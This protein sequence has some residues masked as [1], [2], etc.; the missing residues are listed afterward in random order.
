MSRS[1][2]S[3]LRGLG[4]KVAAATVLGVIVFALLSFYGDVRA[5]QKNL[6]AFDWW[7][8]VPGFA[9]ATANYAVRFLRWQ[10]YL[11]ILGISVPV[12]ES[13]LVFTS[14]FVMSV[15]PGKVGEVFKSLLLYES[16]GTPIART[17]PIVVAERLTDLIALVLLVAIGGMAFEKALPVVLLG[18]GVALCLLVAAAWRPAGEMGLGLI[19]RMPVLGRLAPRMREAYESLYGM[20]RAAPLL[21]STG[22]SVLA[23]FLECVSLHVIVHGFPG[24]S[25][26]WA[27]ST[28]AYSA[29]T[30]VGGLAMMPGGLG[31]T[32]AGMTGFL[33]GLGSGAISPAIATATTMLVRIATLWWAVALGVG[34][35]ALFRHR[36]APRAPA[37]GTGEPEGRP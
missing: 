18:G 8:L 29:P 14:G 17:A 16:Q 33:Q 20:T 6:Q 26:S 37:D 13:A 10:Y 7:V 35:L 3:P 22:L 27:A 11:Y 12:G 4:R 28:F 1:T 5:L 23:W 34:A 2:P 15:T 32:E 21:V 31:I 19:G 9:L 36:A 24:V 30:I 25:L